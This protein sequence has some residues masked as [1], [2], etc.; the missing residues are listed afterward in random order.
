MLQ[1]EG[2]YLV[3]NYKNKAGKIDATVQDNRTM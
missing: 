1:N 2:G 3:L